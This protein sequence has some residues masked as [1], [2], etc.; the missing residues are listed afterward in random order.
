MS[1]VLL[2]CCL[3]VWWFVDT[4]LILLLFICYLSFCFGFDY[5]CLSWLLFVFEFCC[6][7]A[8]FALFLRIAWVKCWGFIVGEFSLLIVGSWFVDLVC[9]VDWFCFSWL[10][11]FC[12]LW[13]VVA[14]C[15]E[16][17]VFVVVFW[18]LLWILF[19][20]G[21]VY[22]YFEMILIIVICVVLVLLYS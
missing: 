19:L 5:W 7:Y 10:R 16:N 1:F 12:L 11:M 21:V 14:F 4:G 6:M 3:V 9:V 2:G 13:L 20:F 17:L 8:L 18:L 22:L 15:L